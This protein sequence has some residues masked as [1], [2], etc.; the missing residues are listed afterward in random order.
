MVGRRRP[1][2]AKLLH[3][4]AYNSSNVFRMCVEHATMP[5]YWQDVLDAIFHLVHAA[6]RRRDSE[7]LEVLL[8]RPRQQLS[9]FTA[10]DSPLVPLW[11]AAFVDIANIAGI[12]VTPYIH[13][14]PLFAE[15]LRLVLAGT[16]PSATDAAAWN[17]Y[18]SPDVLWA[19]VCHAQSTLAR[20][21]L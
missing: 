19:F 12:R 13:A 10:P 8:R 17:M 3:N 2:I 11:Q 5:T 6:A 16:L 1:T 14:V 4:D 20:L 9:E 21:P 18:T 15:Y 7:Q